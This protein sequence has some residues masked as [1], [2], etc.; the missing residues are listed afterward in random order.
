VLIRAVRVVPL[1]ILTVAVGAL[2]V[3][4]PVGAASGPGTASGPGGGSGV[5]AGVTPYGVRAPGRLAE[6]RIAWKPCFM[7]VWIALWWIL[8]TAIRTLSWK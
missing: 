4:G 8:L 7:P 1:S 6:Q 2:A 5:W 3:A